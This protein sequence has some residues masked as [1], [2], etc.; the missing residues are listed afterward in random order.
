[1]QL[2][3]LHILIVDD[4]RD[5]VQM[6]ARLLAHPQRSIAAATSVTEAVATARRQSPDILV[7]DLQFDDGDGCQLLLQIRQQINPAIKGIVITG[8]GLE[9]DRQRCQQ[10][11]F[12]TVLLKPVSLTAVTAAVD[13][14]VEVVLRSTPEQPDARDPS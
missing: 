1:L 11:G 9:V 4:H 2:L 5:T 7:T 3:P 10:A 12:M 8:H 6:M 13:A 14:A